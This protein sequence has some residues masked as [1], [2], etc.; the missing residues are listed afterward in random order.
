MAKRDKAS[1]YV[2]AQQLLYTLYDAQ[3]EMDKRDR[4]VLAVRLLDHTEQIIANFSLAFKSD[5]KLPYVDTML[6]EFEIVKVE[7]RFA[8]EKNIIKS[9]SNIRRLWES[10]DA[11]WYRY[12]EMD[13]DRL[14]VV[15]REG[16]SHHRYNMKLFKTITNYERK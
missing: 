14:C 10:I 15:P 12:V 11:G 9:P 5:D 6:A 8:I 2:D 16:C 3:F 7:L 4:P 1:I 13:W